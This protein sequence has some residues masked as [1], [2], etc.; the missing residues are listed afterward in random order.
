MDQRIQ[1]NRAKEK[2]EEGRILSTTGHDTE[3]E[4]IYLLIENHTRVED[5]KW[6]KAQI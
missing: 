1:I 5:Q 4:E 2:S 3:T 6:L